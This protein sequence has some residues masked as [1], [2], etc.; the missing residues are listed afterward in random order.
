VVNLHGVDL[1][2]VEGDIVARGFFRLGEELPDEVSDIDLHLLGELAV[3]EGNEK[4]FELAG[5]TE[6]LDAGVT[7]A[8]VFSLRLRYDGDVCFGVDG[9]TDAGTVD[10]G[11]ELGMGL[12]VDPDAIVLECDLW[13]FGINEAARVR[14]S[15]EVVAVAGRGE[16]L[17]IERALKSTGGNLELSGMDRARS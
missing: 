17:L 4:D 8:D 11:A 2:V 13:V 5:G 6:V 3:E 16:E 1:E 9:D 12:D 7:E 15:L 10:G 14:L